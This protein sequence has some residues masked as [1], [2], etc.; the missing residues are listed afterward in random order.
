MYFSRLTSYAGSPIVLNI[1]MNFAVENKTAM[2]QKNI[3]ILALYL[4]RLYVRL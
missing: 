1:R 2:Y 3:K 4:M